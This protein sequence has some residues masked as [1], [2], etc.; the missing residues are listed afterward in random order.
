MSVKATRTKGKGLTND[1]HLSGDGS[2]LCPQPRHTRRIVMQ[3]RVIGV[4]SLSAFSVSIGNVNSFVC[5]KVMMT[6]D[7]IVGYLKYVAT[8]LLCWPEVHATMA[9]LI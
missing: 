1:V 3:I 2:E 6:H 7:D 4:Y 8:G 5:V 9:L